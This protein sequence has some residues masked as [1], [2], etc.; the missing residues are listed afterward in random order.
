M[1]NQKGLFY[2]L[3]AVAIAIVIIGVNQLSQAASTEAI[4]ET[5]FTRGQGRMMSG[6]AN[7]GQ[8]YGRM[9]DEEKVSFEA[10]RAEIRA[11]ME[12]KRPAIEAAI[13][14]KDYNAWV[15]AVCSDCPML[16]KVTADNFDEFIKSYQL[17][18]SSEKPGEG[19][20][21]G[22]K[23]NGSYPMRGMNK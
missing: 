2:G 9:T 20:G 18:Q 12:A 17:R 15:K 16:K 10:K 1:K 4:L 22:R 5:N 8:G 7:Q 6:T 21:I 3:T 13:S 14:A 11:E 19:L 23:G